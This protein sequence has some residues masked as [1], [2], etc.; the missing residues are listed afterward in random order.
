[1]RSDYYIYLY[2]DPTDSIPFYVG[3]GCSGRVRVRDHLNDSNKHLHNKILKIGPTNVLIS[4]LVSNVSESEAFYWE[5]YYIK[6]YG[7]RDLGTGTLCNLTEGGDGFGVM[8]EESRE[9]IRNF[10]RGNSYALGYHHTKETIERIQNS[11]K[12]NGV[13]RGVFFRVTGRISRPPVSS[14]TREKMSRA[15]LGNTGRL[16]Q[17]HTEETKKKIG[18]ANRG[19][20]PTQKARELSRLRLLGKKTQLGLTRSEEVKSKMSEAQRVR[21]KNERLR[22]LSSEE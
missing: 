8:S 10:H 22:S 1:M 7:R 16:G 12:R 17:K 5:R 13:K 4:F 21:R 20:I 19:R 6:L 3:K 9:K 15:K 14:V 11:R 18:L 2:S